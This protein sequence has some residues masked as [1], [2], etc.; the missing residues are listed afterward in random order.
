M[1]SS[2]FHLE[3]PNWRKSA[4]Q[5]VAATALSVNTLMGLRPPCWLGRAGEVY[6]PDR[7]DEVPREIFLSLDRQ[8]L[9]EDVNDSAERPHWWRCLTRSS[10]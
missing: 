5:T 10:R 9:S 2:E 3:L 8:Q 6:R 4:L 1:N 7:G